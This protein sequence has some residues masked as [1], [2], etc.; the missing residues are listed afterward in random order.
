MIAMAMQS[1]L[2]KLKKF[3]T[4]KM[5]LEK[6]QSSVIKHWTD[7][8]KGKH[9]LSKSGDTASKYEI[10]CMQLNKVTH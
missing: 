10:F 1:Q 6:A 5:S 9:Y 4:E 2:K 3:M 8:E 7:G